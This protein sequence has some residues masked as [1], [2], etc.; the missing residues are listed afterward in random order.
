MVLDS[1]EAK[2]A[3]TGHWPC[4]LDLRDALRDRK[5]ERGSDEL[6]FRNR[7]WA[8][9]DSLCRALGEKTVGV[10]LGIDLESLMNTG[11][12]LVFRVD[13][14]QSIEDFMASWLIAFAF[15]HRASSDDKFNQ[16]PLIF[17]LD[18]QRSVLRARR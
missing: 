9:I 8:R 11:P 15:E 14:E 2:R 10:E 5:E 7:C 1:L 4:L 12:L 13:L 16:K 6:R 18:E 17:V 3:S